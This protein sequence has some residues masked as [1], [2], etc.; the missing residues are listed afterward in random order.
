MPDIDVLCFVNIAGGI[1]IEDK[2]VLRHAPRSALSIQ[3]LARI[4]LVRN[5]QLAQSTLRNAC[6]GRPLM[7]ASLFFNNQ[8]RLWSIEEQNLLATLIPASEAKA[9]GMT[10]LRVGSSASQVCKSGESLLPL[11]GF[12]FTTCRS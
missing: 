7:P 8:Q 5:L 2:L 10:H 9:D 4:S 12:G 6:R 1:T 3:F 11:A